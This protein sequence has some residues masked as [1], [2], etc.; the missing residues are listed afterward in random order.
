MSDLSLQHH[1]THPQALHEALASLS[2]R[3]A[4][5]VVIADRDF[6]D[7]APGRASECRAR[8]LALAAL[9]Q[10]S[11]APLRCALESLLPPQRGLAHALQARLDGEAGHACAA[12]RL[13]ALQLALGAGGVHAPD[14]LSERVDALLGEAR[15]SG[16][17]LV[18]RL[19][20]ETAAAPA[21]ADEAGVL[22][23]LLADSQAVAAQMREHSASVRM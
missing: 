23:R 8:A 11:G 19:N 10:A 21:P 12:A 7:A 6:I 4:L 17:G 22:A 5:T 3:H 16:H 18:L 15:P 20:L 14:E 13:A 9:C 2:Q 1:L